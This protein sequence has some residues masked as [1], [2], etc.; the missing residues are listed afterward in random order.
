MVLQITARSVDMFFFSKLRLS[1]G[2]RKTLP[3]FLSEEK[4]IYTTRLLTINPK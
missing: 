3:G 4:E 2:G 1:G